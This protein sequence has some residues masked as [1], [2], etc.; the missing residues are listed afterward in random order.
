[1]AE[2]IGSRTAAVADG[3]TGQAEVVE[4]AKCIAVLAT[5]HGA[6]HVLDW[7]CFDRMSHR[8]PCQG[9]EQAVPIAVG[10]PLHFLLIFIEPPLAL[11]H[12]VR[13]LR[14]SAPSTPGGKA[15]FHLCRHLPLL[16]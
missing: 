7:A 11:G 15:V 4:A 1:G 8:L 14:T 12:L 6:R 16:W 9:H 3:P 2:P 10:Q 5:V 13:T